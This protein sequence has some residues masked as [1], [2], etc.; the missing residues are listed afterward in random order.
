MKLMYYRERKIHSKFNLVKC[1]LGVTDKTEVSR[2]NRGLIIVHPL[3]CRCAQDSSR[4][5]HKMLLWVYATS[6]SL[7][8]SQESAPQRSALP[9]VLGG[10]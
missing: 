2:T 6:S 9:L 10:R 7:A 1:P 5:A 8:E 4:H 3:F